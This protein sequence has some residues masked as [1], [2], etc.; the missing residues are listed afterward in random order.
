MQNG[1][2]PT[3]NFDS[4]LN[5]I[6]LV[7]IILTNDGQGAIYYN[8]YRAVGWVPAT[9]FWILLVILGQKIIINLFVA[10]LLQNFDEGQLKMKLHEDHEGEQKMQSMW[11]V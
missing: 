1:I 11:L 10:I 6:S 2:P 8:Y 5:A 7:F 9:I 4:F 3:F